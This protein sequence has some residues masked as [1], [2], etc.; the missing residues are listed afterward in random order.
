MTD[1]PTYPRIILPEE[2]GEE[3]YDIED[4]E[5]FGAEV[6]LENGDHYTLNFYTPLRLSQILDRHIE[7]GE[8]WLAKLNVILVPQVTLK[9]AKQCVQALWH[10]GYFKHLKP[11][12]ANR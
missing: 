5:W 4:N 9:T 6:E 8:P 2:I 10:K 7:C 1:Q 11:D 12:N 3:L